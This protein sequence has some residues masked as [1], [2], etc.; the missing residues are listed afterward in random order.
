MAGRAAADERRLMSKSAYARHRGVSPAMVTHWTKA[1]RIAIVDGKVDA[2][3]SD[4]MLARTLDPARGGKGGKSERPGSRSMNGKPGG[5][6]NGNPAGFQEQPE[7]VDQVVAPPTA[8]ATF[9]DARARRETFAASLAEVEFR[10][11]VGELVELA[12]VNAGIADML[13]MVRRAVQ[14]IPD[15]LATQ[16]AAEGDPRKCRILMSAECERT[17]SDLAAAIDA[18]PE[19][20]TATRQ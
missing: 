13:G 4:A 16:V 20:L 17:L 14:R 11:R 5:K 8:G 3:E 18:L 2:F 12:R 9:Q 6:P 19:Q 7:V 10:K 1:D 15:A